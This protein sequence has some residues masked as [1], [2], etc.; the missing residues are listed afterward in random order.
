MPDILIYTC[1]QGQKSARS[2]WNALLNESTP[3]GS[4]QYLTF[5]KLHSILFVPKKRIHA[6]SKFFEVSFYFSNKLCVLI[7]RY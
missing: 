7:V 6:T 3:V 5:L 4:I 1:L 2:G